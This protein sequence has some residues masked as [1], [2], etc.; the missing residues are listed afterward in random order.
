MFHLNLR[1]GTKATM[2]NDP[3]VASAATEKSE[4]G[5]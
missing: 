5:H 1:E 2:V 4:R 3:N